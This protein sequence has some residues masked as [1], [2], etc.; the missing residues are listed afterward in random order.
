MAERYQTD[1]EAAMN[2]YGVHEHIY[3]VTSDNTQSCV[4]ARRIY[5]AKYVRLVSVNDQAHI[6]DLLM[7]DICMA[8]WLDDIVKK[9]SNVAMELHQ[10]RKLK[11]KFC[12]LKDVYNATV[13][14][15]NLMMRRNKTPQS[16]LV[17]LLLDDVLGLQH[18]PCGDRDAEVVLRGPQKRN[19]E[20]VHI[21]TAIMLK[22]SSMTRFANAGSVIESFV[23]S[24]LVLLALID[25]EEFPSLF[26]IRGK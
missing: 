26:T 20:M 19:A 5:E 7:D 21:D 1:I 6:A 11:E 24:H 10:L 17:E 14:K 13:R 25:C 3:A 2:E 18:T 9:N 23:R 4:N 8:S 22:K 12:E 16:G 15:V